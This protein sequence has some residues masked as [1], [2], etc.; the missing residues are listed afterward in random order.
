[1]AKAPLSSPAE[2]GWENW[3]V[4]LLPFAL[5]FGNLHKCARDFWGAKSLF[6]MVG[7]TGFEP[8]TPPTPSQVRYR[9]ALRSEPA[10][11]LSSMR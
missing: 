3:P 9:A 4:F 11:G 7:A 10:A 2:P 8:A 1:M 5:P 6:Y